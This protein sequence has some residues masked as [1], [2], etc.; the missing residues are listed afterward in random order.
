MT[1][2]TSCYLYSHTLPIDG[3]NVV[4]G[5]NEEFV[6]IEGCCK[7]NLIVLKDVKIK[8]LCSPKIFWGS[9]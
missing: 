3:H 1:S 5:L 9:I 4:K 8:N 6:K 2:G 7:A